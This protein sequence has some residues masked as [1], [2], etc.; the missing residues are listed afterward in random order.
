MKNKSNFF[1]ELLKQ[2]KKIEITL[3]MLHSRYFRRM[4]NFQSYSKFI[5]I[6]ICLFMSIQLT[7]ALCTNGDNHARCIVY[8]QINSYR[9]GLCVLSQQITLQN[10]ETVNTYECQCFGGE[11]DKLLK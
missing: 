11:I 6:L 1:K 5:G 8:C 10:K 2:G 9:H 7:L 4:P 3:L